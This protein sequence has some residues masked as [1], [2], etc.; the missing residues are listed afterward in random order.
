MARKNKLSS[1]EIIR[2]ISKQRKSL[3]ELG[4]KK[5]GIF[6]SFVKGTDNKSSDIDILVTFEEE[7]FHT[8]SEVL[9][10]LKRILKRKIDLVVEE[11]LI[12]ELNYVKKEARYVRL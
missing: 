12:P 11:G 1:E 7:N 10:L 6:G 4:V 3:K 2:E 5:I 9:L 8:Y